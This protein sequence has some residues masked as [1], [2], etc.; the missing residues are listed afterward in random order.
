LVDPVGN[1]KRRRPPRRPRSDAPPK[2]LVIFDPNRAL[3]D[4]AAHRRP[5]SEGER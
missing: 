4:R 1:S 3:L 5:N 2:Q